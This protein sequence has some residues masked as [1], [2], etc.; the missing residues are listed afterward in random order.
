MSNVL[1]D[2]HHAG[3]FHSLQLLGD[4]LRWNIHTP[5][6]DDW[7]DRDYWT[8]GREA[9]GDDRLRAQFLDT[10]DAAWSH[11]QDFMGI[12]LTKDRDYP[13]RSIW[14]VTLSQARQMPWSYVVAT[15]Q[16]NQRGFARFAREVGA[17]YLYQVGNTGQQVDW[18][19]D[20]IALVSS[21]VPIL[22][23]GIRYHQEMHAAYAWRGVSEDP[24]VIR[25]FVQYFPRTECFGLSQQM[26]R[27]L[28]DFGW[29]LHG[30]GCPDGLVNP[31]TAVADTMAASGWGYH[32]KPTGDGFGHVLWGWAALGRP[33]IGH[34]SHYKGKLGEVLWRD[35]ETCIDLDQHTPE[36]AAD[37]IRDIS[38]HPKWHAEMCEAMRDAFAANY[39]PAADAA[40]IARLLGATT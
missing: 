29:Y 36:E 1:L 24:H 16:D 11:W 6:G 13:D 8:F 30:A 12:W 7:W 18:S 34:A 17:K 26:W 28:D 19:L 21:E 40:N 31:T 23:R 14:G 27:A 9:Y 38:A 3:L 4:R 2:R 37:L 20:P 39:D 32:C 10:S 22:G 33:L 5:V 35:M 25:S 15:V